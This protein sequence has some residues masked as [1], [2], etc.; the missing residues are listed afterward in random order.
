MSSMAKRLRKAAKRRDGA[1]ETPKARMQRAPRIAS[2]F[3]FTMNAKITHL[4]D[5]DLLTAL[6]EYARASG[7][8]YFQTRE[9]DAW[10]G[11]R[12]H[13]S[14]VTQRFGGWKKALAIIG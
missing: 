8:R 10:A 7:F 9:F 13:S 14:T 11:R 1:Q 4:S 5:D 6:E 12:C 3:A 2:P